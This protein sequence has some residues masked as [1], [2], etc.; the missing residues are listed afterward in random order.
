MNTCMHNPNEAQI[1]DL[2]VC[3]YSAH[4]YQ[5]CEKGAIISKHVSSIIRNVFACS[6]FKIK[7]TGWTLDLGAREILPTF[8]AH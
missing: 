1:F 7:K 6:R 2:L 5:D 4:V 8:S 3:R